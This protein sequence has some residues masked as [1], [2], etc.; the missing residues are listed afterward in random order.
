MNIISPINQLGYGIA[1]L[2]ILKSFVNNE[3]YDNVC[4][5]PLGQPEVTNEKDLEIVRECIKNAQFPSF[6]DPCLR[7]CHQHD[8][9]QWVGSGRRI[10][11]PFFELD[12]FSELEKYHLNNGVDRLFV[13]SQWAKDVCRQ[14]LSLPEHKI[15]IIHLGVDT[16]IFKPCDPPES[17]TTVFFNCGKWEVRKG[18][19]VLIDI[20]NKA[21]KPDDDVELWMMTENVFLSSAQDQAWKERYLNSPL[22]S[23]IKFIPRVKT[24]L[25]VYNIM[26]SVDCGVFPS[27]AEGWNLEALELLSCGKSLIITNYS[28]H[29]EFCNDENS[30]L[31]DI[32]NLELARDD[33]FFRQGEGKWGEISFKQKNEFISHMRNIHSAKQSGNLVVNDAGIETGKKFTWNRTSEE[34][35]KY[36]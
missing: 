13:T 28:A 18:H 8:M 14:E 23:K 6:K 34:I 15:N 30:S 24:Q 22:G 3:K 12:K 36:V 2:N 35:R 29:Q 27:R 9:S 17:K 7:V 1:G 26:R 4:L 32:T 16:D 19:D 10:G 31:V 21:F 5:W 11:F 25:E 20:F 33:V